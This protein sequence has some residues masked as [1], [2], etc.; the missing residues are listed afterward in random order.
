MPLGKKRHVVDVLDKY[1]QNQAYRYRVRFDC[2]HLATVSAR[3]SASF[4]PVAGYCNHP[5]CINPAPLPPMRR[6]AP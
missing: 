3:V 4:V 6:L 1:R 2:G 5:E